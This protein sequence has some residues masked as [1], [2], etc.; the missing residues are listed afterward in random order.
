MKNEVLIGREGNHPRVVLHE[1][2]FLIM[3]QFALDNQNR[4][5][6]GLLLGFVSSPEEGR[7][8][9]ITVEQFLPIPDQQGESRFV[10]SRQDWAATLAQ[11]ELQ[12]P[13]YEIVGWMHTHPG[14]GTFL[15]QLDKEQHQRFFKEPW[16]LAY[17]VDPHHMARAFYLYGDQEWRRVN[18]YYIQQKDS[19][20]KVGYAAAPGARRRKSSWTTAAVV[21]TWSLVILVALG[22]VLLISGFNPLRREEPSQE[23]FTPPDNGEV[24]Q[25]QAADSTPPQPAAESSLQRTPTVPQQ[26]R[27]TP[28]PAA[29][30]E[31]AEETV[32]ETVGTEEFG[33]RQY[34]VQAG[35]NLWTIAVNQLGDGSR[36]SEIAE[37]N[38]LQTNAVLPV[39]L[40]LDLPED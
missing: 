17:V 9:Q 31:T 35:D 27:P 16:H 33:L 28:S 21:A 38:D 2:V 23:V 22:G 7:R 6:G 5:F 8:Q 13:G 15:S 29:A 37:L 32:E 40:T 20:R 14:F 18:G 39:G 19:D 3:D 11:L 4:E 25:R 24:S 36:Y 10:I 12:F 26:P 34:Q 1:E 30:E